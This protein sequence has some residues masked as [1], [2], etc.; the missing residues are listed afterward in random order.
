MPSID[1][2]VHT[3]AGCSPRQMAPIPKKYTVYAFFACLLYLLYIHIHKCFLCAKH[4]EVTD[5]GKHR[6]FHGLAYSN[7]WFCPCALVLSFRGMMRVRATILIRHL[8]APLGLVTLTKRSMRTID[9]P[10][11]CKQTWSHHLTQVYKFAIAFQTVNSKWTVLMG[12]LSIEKSRMMCV[13]CWH[14]FYDTIQI[15]VR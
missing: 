12:L 3:A 10:H 13:L 11:K 8:H 2:C 5:K 14:G 9:E 6:V 1:L 4:D 15:G 7:K